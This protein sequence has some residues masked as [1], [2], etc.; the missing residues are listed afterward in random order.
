MRRWCS[1][2][3]SKGIRLAFQSSRRVDAVLVSTMR[4]GQSEVS[5]GIRCRSHLRGLEVSGNSR[6]QADL[7]PAGEWSGKSRGFASGENF[8]L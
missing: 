2:G 6:N 5:A 7:G 1:E 8:T 3:S 4:E